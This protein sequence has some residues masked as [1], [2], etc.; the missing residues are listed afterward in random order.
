MI[1]GSPRKREWIKERRNELNGSSGTLVRLVGLHSPSK[2]FQSSN[3]ARLQ[4]SMITISVYHGMLKQ[5][6]N[7]PNAWFMVGFGR[8]MVAKI[9]RFASLAGPPVIKLL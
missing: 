2:H 5:V 4:N 7:T 8:Y 6:E 9:I 3:H 1:L